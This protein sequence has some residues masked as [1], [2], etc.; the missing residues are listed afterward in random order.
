M[1]TILALILMASPA[2]ADQTSTTIEDA[3]GRDLGRVITDEE[4]NTTILDNMG[5]QQ[6]RTVTQQDGTVIIYDEKGRRIRV[7][8]TDRSN[9]DER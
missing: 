9:D 4:G 6:G 8:K 1:R 3:N 7:I 2:L 5:R